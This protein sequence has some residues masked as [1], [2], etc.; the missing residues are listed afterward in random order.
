MRLGEAAGHP[1]LTGGK[2]ESIG[3]EEKEMD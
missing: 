2:K 3:F 1:F